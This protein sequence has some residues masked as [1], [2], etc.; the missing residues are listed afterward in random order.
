[1]NK[2]FSMLLTATSLTSQCKRITL[3]WG[4]GAQLLFNLEFL[5]KTMQQPVLKL[6]C[7]TCLHYSQEFSCPHPTL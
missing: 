5:P 1:M 4:Q 6:S 7:P 3:A 2:G